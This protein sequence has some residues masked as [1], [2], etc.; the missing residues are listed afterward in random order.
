MGP[1][2]EQ[3]FCWNQNALLKKFGFGNHGEITISWMV[4]PV[5]ARKTAPRGLWRSVAVWRP[6]PRH[7]CP[8]ASPIT[9]ARHRPPPSAAA[10]RIAGPGGR[11]HLSI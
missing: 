7:R 5:T 2:N 9:S 8:S 6:I 11:S 1:A 3:R 10:C 4:K